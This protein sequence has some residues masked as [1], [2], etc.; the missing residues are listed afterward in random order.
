MLFNGIDGVIKLQA[1]INH[2]NRQGGLGSFTALLLVLYGPGFIMMTPASYIQISPGL[3][4]MSPDSPSEPQVQV[5][6][7]G[8]E[9]LIPLLGRSR[10]AAWGSLQTPLGLTGGRCAAPRGTGGT[11]MSSPH[12]C[13]SA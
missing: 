2:Q 5:S 11:D 9:D 13:A 12:T 10:A 4:R 6:E 7:R 3:L 8:K 1:D